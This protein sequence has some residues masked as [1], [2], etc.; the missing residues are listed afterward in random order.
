MEITIVNAQQAVVF[1]PNGKQLRLWCSAG[2]VRQMVVE[3]LMPMNVNRELDPMAYARACKGMSEDTSV[4][5]I[6]A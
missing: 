5:A 3:W 4:I 1:Y 2:N 6:A